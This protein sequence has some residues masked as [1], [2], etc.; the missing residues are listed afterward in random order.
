[1]TDLLPCNTRSYACYTTLQA[2]CKTCTHM[3]KFN[4][5]MQ[6]CSF[7]CMRVLAAPQH[8]PRGAYSPAVLFHTSPL[9]T[10]NPVATGNS[11]QLR[12]HPRRSTPACHQSS[13]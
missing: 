1:M 7:S 4:T 10:S 11:R 3:R 12:C 2:L 5:G 6:S 8:Q 9:P 13:V